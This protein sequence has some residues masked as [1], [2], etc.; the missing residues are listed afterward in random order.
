[1]D[2]NSQKG[3][4]PLEIPLSEEIQEWM[5]QIFPKTLPSP[6]LYRIV[7]K[8]APLFQ[9][10]ITTRFIGPTG[11]FDKGRMS[12]KL[13]ELLILR[14]CRANDNLYE[15]TLHQGTISQ[16]MGLTR[17][18]IDDVWNPTVDPKLWET[19]ELRLF[20]LIDCLI[21]KN[22]ISDQLHGSLS[23]HYTESELI[24]IILLIGFYTSVSMLVQFAKPALDH[25]AK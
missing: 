18:Q 1:M 2:T 4:A 16:K 24:E 11:V 21:D 17:Q 7:A 5:D 14:T 15:Y 9:E 12:P 19:S 10:L 13:R 8:N 22:D 6:N 20:D 23:E 3:I 25:Y